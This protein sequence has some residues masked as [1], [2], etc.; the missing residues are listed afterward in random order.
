MLVTL[1]ACLGVGLSVNRWLF[2]RRAT[3]GLSFGNQT[4]AAP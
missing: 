2:G 4:A 1:I 3:L